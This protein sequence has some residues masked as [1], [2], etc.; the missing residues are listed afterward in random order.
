MSCW[1]EEGEKEGRERGERGERGRRGGKKQEGGMR[2]KRKGVGVR[3]IDGA[4][5][6]GAV[7]LRVWISPF[8]A[9]YIKVSTFLSNAHWLVLYFLDIN[10]HT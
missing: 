6:Y 2:W 3:G 1:G 9:L 7:R 8:P 10:T 4:G 5:M